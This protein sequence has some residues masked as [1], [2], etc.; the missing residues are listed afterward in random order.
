MHCATLP[1][2]TPRPQR[3]SSKLL[4]YLRCSLLPLPGQPPPP[5]LAGLWPPP[6]L[7]S[8]PASW[9]LLP[10]PGGCCY[11]STRGGELGWGGGA[12][13]GPGTRGLL[14]APT[15]TQPGA[16]LGGSSALGWADLGLA[17]SVAHERR[18]RRARGSAPAHT[19]HCTKTCTPFH[20]I[21]SLVG[22]STRACTRTD[23]L[24]CT[25]AHV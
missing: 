14:Q 1:G 18:L 2:Q 16:A 7:I 13:A 5:P 11:L 6:T 8:S 24:A 15:P 17:P 3:A 20:H 19:H 10:V 23:T 4:P 22:R 12:E 25:H 9:P 21:H